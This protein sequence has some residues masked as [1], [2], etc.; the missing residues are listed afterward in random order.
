MTPNERALRDALKHAESVVAGV[1]SGDS[2]AKSELEPAMKKVDRI[3]ADVQRDRK[4]ASMIH[5]D[6]PVWSGNRPT[7]GKGRSVIE[8]LKSSGF[9]PEGRKSGLVDPFTFY[10]LKADIVATEATAAPQRVDGVAAFGQDS[11]MVFPNVPVT[12]IPNVGAPT[13]FDYLRQSSRTYPAA[14]DATL[15]LAHTTA[16]P[17]TDLVVVEAQ[18]AT[19][20][21]GTVSSSQ[22]NALLSLDGLATIIRSELQQVLK[23]DIDK[24]V[25]DGILA[26]GNKNTLAQ[27]TD[28]VLDA[29]FKA[30]GDLADD[31]FSGNLI[32]MNPND[33]ENVYLAKDADDHYLNAAGSPLWGVKTVTSSRVAA[34]TVIVADTASMRLY[35]SDVKV[36]VD[37]FTEFSRNRSFLRAEHFGVLTIGQGTG[38]VDLTLS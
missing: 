14:G 18:A 24:H 4:L 10:G 19:L 13:R 8:Q 29:I 31:G 5:D 26:D 36:D 35:L 38:I 3:R 17:T 11:R 15:A 27:G 1:K 22:P 7:A 34:G 21:F 28:T 16:K 32:A 6:L 9:D 23:I 2:K 30:L 12:A 33:A 20:V 25:V 37:P